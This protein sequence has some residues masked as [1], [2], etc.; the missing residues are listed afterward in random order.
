VTTDSR[1]SRLVQLADVLT[2][3]TVAYVGG[4]EKYA[5][6]T[7]QRARPIV[8][9]DGG[10]IGGVGVKIHPDLRYHWLFGDSH[11][12]KGGVGTDLPIKGRSYSNSPTD[13]SYV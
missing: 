1:L 7:F 5:P 3:C 8:R 9:S 2:G 12:W 11:L 4:E 13:S 6:G 10:R